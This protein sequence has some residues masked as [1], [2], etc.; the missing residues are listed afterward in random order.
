MKKVILLTLAAL[1]LAVILFFYTSFN[2]NF[3]SKMLAKHKV[4]KYVE[5]MYKEQNKQLVDSYFN[6]KD[7]QYTFNYEIYNNTIRSSYSFSISGPFF[8]NGQIFSYLQ[9][10]S[11]DTVLTEKF[12][13]DGR[14]WLEGKLREKHIAFDRVDYSVDIPKGYYEEDEV[15]KPHVDQILMPWITVELTDEQQT[16]EQ[17]SQQA[18]AIRQLFIDNKVT[19]YNGNVSMT[20]E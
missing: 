15:W 6:F 7:G 9:S 1:L 13:E 11:M 5:E 17:F 18:E 2:G 8:P 20:R 10:D 4:E 3:I 14:K 12:N 16:E 19:Y